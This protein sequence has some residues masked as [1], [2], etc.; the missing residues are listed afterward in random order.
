MG[1]FIP[2]FSMFEALLVA[3]LMKIVSKYSIEI[4]SSD[5]FYKESSG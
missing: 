5:L 4:L 3:L 1:H 2:H